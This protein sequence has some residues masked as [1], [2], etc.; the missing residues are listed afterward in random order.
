[1]SV[2]GSSGECGPK[3]EAYRVGWYGEGRESGL[4]AMTPRGMPARMGDAQ[5]VS[6]AL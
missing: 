5:N 1:M 3:E 2:I 4:A 6:V